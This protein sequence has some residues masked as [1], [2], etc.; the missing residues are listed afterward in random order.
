MNPNNY[1]SGYWVDT[2]NGSINSTTDQT[3]KITNYISVLP[4]TQ[5]ITN[6]ATGVCCYDTNKN[7]IGTAQTTNDNNTWFYGNR[8]FV[9]LPNTAYVVLSASGRVNPIFIMGKTLPMNNQNNDNT[10]PNL[11]IDYT[12]QYVTFSVPDNQDAH[13]LSTQLHVL[14][15][16]KI[17]WLGDSITAGQYDEQDPLTGTS[18]G[19]NTTIYHEFIAKRYNVLCRNY[20]QGGTG[21]ITTSGGQG[22]F[23]TRASG[24]STDADAVVVFGGT[25]DGL[26]P[27]GTFGNGDNTTV[28]G[29]VQNLI[30]I[31]KG[32]Y[33]TQPI[34]FMINYIN[35]ETAQININNAVRQVC[36]YN[37]IPYIELNETILTKRHGANGTSGDTNI[38]QMYFRNHDGTH[39]NNRGHQILARYITKELEKILKY[40]TYL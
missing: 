24:M 38:D 36:D 32:M 19:Y 14:N 10:D 40:T 30:N 8:P 9:T 16:K 15:G 31:L 34:I 2:T 21:F 33:P 26:Q 28:Y 37:Y 29:A 13:S 11:G 27:L 35:N 3:A 25:N 23:Q 17:N 18:L 12:K 1:I 4:N 22:N 5:Y 39:P 20:G 6:F 7:Y